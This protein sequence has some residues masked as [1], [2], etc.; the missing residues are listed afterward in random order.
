[1][2]QDQLA[3]ILGD[4]WY[5]KVGK[6]GLQIGDKMPDIPFGQ[7]LNNKTGKQRFTELKNKLIIL[8]FWST[9][10]A[11]C[12]ERF[13][14][15]EKLQ[16]EFADQIVIFLVNPTE[17]IGQIE[18]RFN[19]NKGAK[20]TLPDLPLIVAEKPYTVENVNESLL[21]NLFPHREV[22]HHVWIDK[23]GIV[24]LIG[25]ADNTYAKKIKDFLQGKEIFVKKNSSSIPI[26]DGH[27]NIPYYKLLANFRR[28]PVIS[29]SFITPYNNEMTGGRK[30]IVD[31]AA[32]VRSTYFINQD[33]LSIYLFGPLKNYLRQVSDQIIYTVLEPMWQD[34]VLFDEAIDTSD[35]TF[36]DF[37]DENYKLDTAYLKAFYCVEQ[38]VPLTMSEEQQAKYLL[39]DLNR[40]CRERKGATINLEKKRTLCFA[41]IRTSSVDKVT[42]ADNS[43]ERTGLGYAFK[44]VIE[45]NPALINI[46]TKNKL[47]GQAFFILN[48]TGWASDAT[49]SLPIA[50]KKISSIEELNKALLA[51]D[52]KI[53]EKEIEFEFI[54][55]RK[56][57]NQP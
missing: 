44:L 27:N 21:Y 33:L 3:T 43:P 22:P 6:K 35:F 38:V 36:Y 13:P 55:V 26:M 14:E 57:Q 29:G 28:V 30:K 37:F 41:L 47:S 23:N 50:K 25:S 1:M 20:I 49:V 39:E 10:C 31:S 53:V 5:L 56:H 9:S 4:D 2:A 54:A 11:T 32:A 48:E 17:T 34:F 24:K 12:I 46:F 45:E 8:D 51:Y 18:R 7:V 15:M 40:F 16:K 52:M 42:L 19:K